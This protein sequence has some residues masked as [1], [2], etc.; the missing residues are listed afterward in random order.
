MIFRTPYNMCILLTVTLEWLTTCILCKPLPFLYL[1]YI[2]KEYNKVHR[3]LDNDEIDHVVRLIQKQKELYAS[4]DPIPKYRKGK[5]LHNI[6]VV[7][8]SNV[9]VN[10]IHILN[11]YFF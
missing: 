5:G 10:N 7:S 1:G 2:S 6:H 9:T 3:Y 8:H 11:K 4:K